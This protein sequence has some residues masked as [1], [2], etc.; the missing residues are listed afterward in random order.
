MIN[1]LIR[2]PEV[3]RLTGLKPSTIYKLIR[4]DKFPDGI[5]LTNATTAWDLES[6]SSWI[7]GKI[8]NSSRL[9]NKS[10]LTP[11]GDL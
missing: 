7:D 8:S 5:K 4:L 11:R 2:M 10:K 6:V 1:R 3:V 9:T